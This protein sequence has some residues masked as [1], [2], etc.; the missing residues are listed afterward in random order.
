MR[1]AS[2]SLWHNLSATMSLYAKLELDL[3]LFKVRTIHS[4]MELVSR[5]G[6]E[7][8]KEVNKFQW[9]WMDEK[10]YFGRISL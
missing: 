9:S 4:T 7:N 3:N 1:L 6:R 8:V 10:G 5:D 2:A